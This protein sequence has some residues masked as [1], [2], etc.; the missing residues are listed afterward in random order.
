MAGYPQESLDF[1]INHVILPPRLPQEADAEIT[2]HAAKQ[3][4]LRLLSEE[5]HFYHLQIK[6][7]TNGNASEILEAWAVIKSMLLRCT[8]LVSAEYLSTELLARLFSE[9]TVKSI[10]LLGF[11]NSCC[12]TY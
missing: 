11:S 4:L 9:L 7:N 8:T 1:I 2:S 5:V 6:Q 10:F 3:R 12:L